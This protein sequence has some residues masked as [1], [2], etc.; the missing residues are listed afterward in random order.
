[1]A[2]NYQPVGV[3][4]AHG[5]IGRHLIDLFD[6]SRIPYEIFTGD[7]RKASDVEA[8]YR[9]TRVTTVVHLVGKFVGSEDDL[10]A[11]NVTATEQ[12]LAEGIRFGLN[13]FIYVSSGAVYGNPV[14]ASGSKETDIPTPNTTYGKT[15]LLAERIVQDFG[16]RHAIGTII[17]RL[18][19]VYGDGNTKGVIYELLHSI[20]NTG[21]AT[22]YGTGTQSRQFVHVDD[23]CH[24]ILLALTHEKSD[25]FNIASG[26]PYTINDVIKQLHRYYTFDVIYKPTNNSLSAVYLDY[27]RATKILGYAPNHVQLFADLKKI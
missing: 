9:H 14:H 5:F 26:T 27:S 1:M 23:V 11:S 24:A 18:P 17:L 8:F 16:A 19:S 22:I 20:T 12:L 21:Q 2:I 7:C 6:S 3:T 13:K 10:I 25:I 4:G 15:K